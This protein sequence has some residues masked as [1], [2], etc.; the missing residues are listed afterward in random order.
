MADESTHAKHAETLL[1]HAFDMVENQDH[2]QASEKIWGSV[3]HTLKQIAEKHGWPHESNND[4]ARIAGYLSAV[5]D[6]DDIRGAYGRARSFHTNFYE[7]EYEMEDIE[8]GL[9]AADALI[10]LLQDADRQ[11]DGGALPPNR[12]A[13]PNDYYARQQTTE[14][15]SYVNALRKQGLSS[16][17][18]SAAARVVHESKR[19]G[20]AGVSFTV[21]AARHRVTI[22]KDGL[23]KVAKPR[24]AA[25]ATP[26]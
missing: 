11:L 4:L 13:S 2:L 7:D 19:R 18:A 15:N 24:S 12:A 3:A 6:N 17:D 23:P 5:T 9:A 26:R 21:G 10:Q 25:S 16:Y 1:N 8:K 20:V 14:M 22:G